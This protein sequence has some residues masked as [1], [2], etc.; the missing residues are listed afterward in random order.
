MQLRV[1]R[2]AEARPRP[3]R[4]PAGA[5]LACL[6]LALVPPLAGR[7]AE[8][9][10]LRPAEI[11][12]EVQQKL[13]VGVRLNFEGALDEAEA[14]WRQLRRLRPADPAVP[15]FEISTLYWRQT[16]DEGNPRYDEA[17]RTRA[18]EALALC[19]KRLAR[20]ER[21][22]EAHFY[23][24]QALMALARLELVRSRI[25]RAGSRGETA[26]GHLERA[27]ELRPDW[28]DAK[29]PLGMYYFYASALPK[30]F[31]WLGWL[32]FVPKGDGPLGLRYLEEVRAGGDLHRWDAAF[33]LLN[34]HT[35][36]EPDHARALALAR[37]LHERFPDNS[38]IHF[39][40]L[41]VL[42]AME[43]W[44]A[45]HAEA[46]VLEAHPG[47]RFHDAGRRRM[48]RVWRAW[49]ELERG[50]P[51]RAL[52]TLSVFE[53]DGPE[54]PSWASAWINLQRGRALDLL[55][56]RERALEHYRRVIALEP[57][58]RSVRAAELAEEGIEARY[59]VELPDVST[60]E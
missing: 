22:A 12:S 8:P 24:G 45:L 58:R 41:E 23:A 19:R 33:I 43:D 28:T 60:G 40:V 18:E 25:L 15:V 56:R 59:A 6:A 55:G 48:A 29:H 42:A 3:L 50:E 54:D 7:G 14:V 44:D 34:I 36:L 47:T 57:P 11:A 32:W 31:S 17:I 21:D 2:A 16:F 9:P 1:T 52:E 46:Q 20:D 10:V 5:G 13:R 53:D 38:L 51:L 26:R 4:R 35:Y 37:E 39:E 49:A 30:V 27:L